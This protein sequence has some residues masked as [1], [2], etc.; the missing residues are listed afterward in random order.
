MKLLVFGN[1]MIEEDRLAI[2]IARS[3]DHEFILC[4][5]PTQIMEHKDA[6]ILDVVENLDKVILIDDIDQLRAHS[7]YSLH[8]F[9]LGFF[10]KLMGN[11]KLIENIQIIGIPQKG[12]KKKI[13]QEIEEI[14]EN[15][16]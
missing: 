7:L 6:V 5:D 11:A 10:L 2:E 15:M 14:L 1:E 13:K 16:E 9:D 4:E 8:D 3:M 12:D